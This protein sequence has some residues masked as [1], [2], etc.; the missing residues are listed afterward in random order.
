[1][2]T[3]PL[4][5]DASLSQAAD[6][7]PGLADAG[8]AEAYARRRAWLLH[9]LGGPTAIMAAADKDRSAPADM[10]DWSG[11]LDIHLGVYTND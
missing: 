4:V 3:F 11:S 8:F 2:R 9:A 10:D 5:P 1:M 6:T 7:L